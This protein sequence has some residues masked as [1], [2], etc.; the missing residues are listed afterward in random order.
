MRL[1]SD[2]IRYD[3]NRGRS[4]LFPNRSSISGKETKGLN[5]VK[6]VRRRSKGT[7]RLPVKR[8]E[9]PISGIR[10]SLSFTRRGR[11]K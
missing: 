7:Q 2:R 4:I 6:C 1:R 3:A 9:H 10:R 11:G 5:F 8:N